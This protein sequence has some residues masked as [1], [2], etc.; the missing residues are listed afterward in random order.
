MP[1]FDES[2][3]ASIN[4]LLAMPEAD[5]E[6]T[7]DEARSTAMAFTDEAITR[8]WATELRTAVARK[9]AK[10]SQFQLVFAPDHIGWLGEL[11]SLAPSA[12]VRSGASMRRASVDS[13]S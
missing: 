7:R 3:T 11:E 13:H 9:Q 4:E 12:L 2:I 1:E 5:R 6:R 10:G 8:Q